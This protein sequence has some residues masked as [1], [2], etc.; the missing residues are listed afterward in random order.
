MA[1]CG[2]CLK[3]FTLFFK[4]R[5][6]FS[7]QFKFTTT[8]SRRYRD[9]PHTLCLHTCKASLR[10]HILP[11]GASVT[12]DAP[13]LIHRY[14]PERFQNSPLQS[15]TVQLQMQSLSEGSLRVAVGRHMSQPV[16]SWNYPSSPFGVFLFSSGLAKFHPRRAQTSTEPRFKRALCCTWAL[17]PH[18]DA[19]FQFS[20]PRS[21]VSCCPKL[22]SISWTQKDRWSAWVLL[23]MLWPG[24][25]FPQ[26]TGD[27]GSR[28]CG[29]RLR[30]R[31]HT[32][33]LCSV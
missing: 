15:S 3:S 28:S 20:A 33:W 4:N 17:H 18:P 14:H 6:H 10:I 2:C 13:A 5:L 7:E 22:E 8:L 16:S 1:F 32:L 21:G 11:E 23:P 9:F 31:N 19:P 24:A 30:G 29:P 25:C 12:I 26:E 27:K